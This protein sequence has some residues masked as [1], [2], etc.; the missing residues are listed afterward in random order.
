MLGG[1]YPGQMYPGGAPPY[2]TGDAYESIVAR[3]GAGASGAELV[4]STTAAA[5]A[6]TKNSVGH[7]GWG[8]TSTSVTSSRTKTV[9][10]DTET[11][12]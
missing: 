6:A 4:A 8:S 2:I 9:I 7:T 10:T 1:I 12:V 3:P 11:E 5:L